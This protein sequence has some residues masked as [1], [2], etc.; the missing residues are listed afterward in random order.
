MTTPFS[1][2]LFS[3][4]RPTPDRP[5]DDWELLKSL[6]ARWRMLVV[7]PIA[8]AAVAGLITLFVPPTFTS[9]TTFVAAGQRDITA[10]LGNFANFATQ[11]G[12]GIPTNPTTSPQF[13]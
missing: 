1:P 5:S 3:G 8:F 13:Y 12:V 9:T 4:P 2:P 10:S 11:L 7:I 6:V